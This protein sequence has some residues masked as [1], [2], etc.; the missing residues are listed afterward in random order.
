M[1]QEIE[2]EQT[3]E[4]SSSVIGRAA[5]DIISLPYLCVRLQY[6]FVA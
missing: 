2:G 5:H 6:R 4:E 1:S 3:G